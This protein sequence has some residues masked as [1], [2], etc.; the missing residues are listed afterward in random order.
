MDETEDTL[1]NIFNDLKTGIKVDGVD[2]TW[3]FPNL[4]V[5]SIEMIVII[6]TKISC[7]P[8]V[9]DFE[10]EDIRTALNITEE[11]AKLIQNFNK[12]FSF[13]HGLVEKYCI[14]QYV[15]SYMLKKIMDDTVEDLPE[16]QNANN[17][18]LLVFIKNF[19][20]TPNTL[21]G[22]NP[23]KYFINSIKRFIYLFCILCL[24][25]S[26]EPDDK[27]LAVSI[28]EPKNNQYSQ[29][30]MYFSPEQ[31]VKEI[32]TLE[33][34]SS[35]KV[36]ITSIITKYDNERNRQLQTI[37]GKIQ[38]LFSKTEFGHLRLETFLEKFNEELR[39][40]TRS[41]EMTCISLISDAKDKGIFKKYTLIDTIEETNE[42][43]EKLNEE[44]KK[45]TMILRKD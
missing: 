25:T 11:Q 3:E 19:D 32:L 4:L 34:S 9:Q 6:L 40:S 13:I 10:S 2:M 24:V 39:A 18:E 16:M 45:Q 44:V 41:I 14:Q 26:I 36:N 38:S 15:I 33:P 22:G 12:Q 5:N 29:G 27:E 20:E 7:L 31:F 17:T 28:V 21:K 8:V 43:L 35:N 30:L 23:M 42:K 1:E 37:I